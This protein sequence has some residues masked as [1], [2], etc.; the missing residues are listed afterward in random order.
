MTGSARRRPRRLRTARPDAWSVG[1][2]S[3]SAT[4]RSAAARPTGVSAPSGDAGPQAQPEHHAL[5]ADLVVARD[6]AR[7]RGRRAGR[8]PFAPGPRVQDVPPAHAADVAV[9]A[10]PGAP[11]VAAAPVAEIVA[12][13]GGLVRR[14][15]TGL[16]PREAGVGEH[17]LGG[18]EAVDDHVLAGH[19]ELAAADLRGHPRAGFDDQRVGREVVGRGAQRGV[20]RGAP[21]V[22]G[23]AR[24]AVD[25]VQADLLEARGARL[26]DGGLRAPGGVGALERR[27]HARH[28]AL[29]PQRQAREAGLAQRCQLRRR[30]P[31]RGWPPS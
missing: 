24:G 6:L 7:G 2:S 25:E 22:G 11:P 3:P 29:H 30:R 28:R 21:V 18:L 17:A 20:E 15:R 13:P 5:Q 19:G 4:W 8:E 27:Q 12:A 26:G 31:T 10:G 14:P 9:R 1:S 23:L 16:V